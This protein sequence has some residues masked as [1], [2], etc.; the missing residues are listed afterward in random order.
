MTKILTQINKENKKRVFALSF[1]ALF[2]ISLMFAQSSTM[3]FAGGDPMC[4]SMVANIFKKT[5]NDDT[6]SNTFMVNGAEVEMERWDKDND[7]LDPT[8]GWIIK[9]TGNKRT[10]LHDVIIGSDLDDLIKPG[11]G[12][13]R[14]CGGDGDDR[15]QGGW[16]DD[17]LFGEA[18]DDLLKGG[19]GTDWLIGG[20]D[21]DEAQGGKG[22][23]DTCVAEVESSCELNPV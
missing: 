2:T 1:A 4:D 15:L 8:D 17:R 7:G 22:N 5:A 10:P 18:G 11:W 12:N 6:S 23:F 21:T 9:G 14:V 19:W 16:G 13:D 20:D 3:A